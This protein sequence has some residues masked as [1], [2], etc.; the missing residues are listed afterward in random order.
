M[1]PLLTLFL[2]ALTITLGTAQGFVFSVAPSASI[3]TSDF[4]SSIAGDSLANYANLGVGANVEMT[5]WFHPAIGL[6]FIAG[7]YSNKLDNQTIAEQLS[8]EFDLNISVTE[9]T[10][11]TIYAMLG[12]GFGYNSQKTSI[13]IHPTVGYGLKDQLSYTAF[14]ENLSNDIESVDLE[15]DVGLMYGVQFSSKFFLTKSFALGFNAGYISGNFESIGT[16]TGIGSI[17]DIKQEFEPSIINAG[18]NVSFRF[19]GGGSKR[20]RPG[21]GFYFG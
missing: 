6:S 21:A 17:S 12:L 11:T 1:R 8:D 14:R 20:H 9:D 3:P 10:Y 19:G 15:S 5:L 13:S 18:V 7:A 16:R 4:G 2:V